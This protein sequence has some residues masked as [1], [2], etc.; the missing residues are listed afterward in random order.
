MCLLLLH[1]LLIGYQKYIII[2][3]KYTMVCVY[4]GFYLFIF[5][6]CSRYDHILNNIHTKKLAFHFIL[7]LNL[8]SHGQC[9]LQHKRVRVT[10]VD[11]T[12]SDDKSREILAQL[13][14]QCSWIEVRHGYSEGKYEYK[15]CGLT[16]TN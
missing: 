5:Y 11:E 4:R 12:H 16:F 14:F 8:P 3:F 2:I 1:I 10:A 13:L 6:G 7:R 15:M 9:T